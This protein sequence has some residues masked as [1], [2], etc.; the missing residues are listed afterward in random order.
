MSAILDTHGRVILQHGRV[1]VVTS[2]FS[3]SIVFAVHSKKTAFS[4]SIVFKSFQSGEFILDRSV[5]ADRFQRCS[6]DDS[7][8]RNKTIPFSLENGVVSTESR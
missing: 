7:L 3:D 2:S 6:V 5:F 8:I 1:V 4:N